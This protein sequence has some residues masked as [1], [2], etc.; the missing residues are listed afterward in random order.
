M[1]LL[2]KKLS[3][4]I[5]LEEMVELNK[6]TGEDHMNQYQQSTLEQAWSLDY[7]P[8]SN[9]TPAYREERWASL[10]KK[11]ATPVVQ[12]P[13]VRRLQKNV[14]RWSVAAS[15]AI[16][17]TVLVL[18]NY[19]SEQGLQ[20]PNVFSTKNGSRSKV[21]MPDGTQVWLNVGS[22][23][24]YDPVKYGKSIREVKLTGEAFFDVVKDKDRPFIIHAEAMNIKVLGTAF[25][26]KA[27]AGDKRT[28]ASVIRGSIEISFDDRPTEKIILKPNEKISVINPAVKTLPG[29]KATVNETAHDE[30]TISV[31]KVTYLPRDSAVV[32]TSWVENMLVFRNRPFNDVA[33][34]MERWY[35]VS[36][37]FSDSSLIDRKLTG[38][39]KNE[40]IT[41]ALNYLKLTVGFEYQFD[42]NNNSVEIYKD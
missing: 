26:V 33:R 36:I 41:D 11:L 21:E 39:F 15:L 24:A 23:L 16:A 14:I 29:V 9:S 40:S 27:Y 13:P 10:N 2:A 34:D 20:Q 17:I 12:D 1:D 19:N 38:S 7:K 8:L 18:F 32:E 28:E 25:N 35:D 3:G 6:L 31:S 37:R 30:S 5:S 22:K 4:E 42:R